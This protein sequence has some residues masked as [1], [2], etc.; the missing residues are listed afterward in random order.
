MASAI[1]LAGDWLTSLGNRR[2]TMGTGNLG[3]LYAAGGIAVSPTQVGL[4]AIDSLAIQPAGGYVFEYVPS[5]GKVK[6]YLSGLASGTISAPDVTVTGGQ[7]AGPA[8][9][10]TPDSAAGVLG[11]TTA[12]DR[13][14]PGGTFG[15]GAQTFTGSNVGFTEAGAIN[16][17][18]ITFTFVAIGR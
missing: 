11:K 14:I 2:Q 5:T 6:A 12:T 16:L 7:A 10:I 3:T 18:A 4:G 17:S 9:Q 15:I 8:L 1:T 13:V